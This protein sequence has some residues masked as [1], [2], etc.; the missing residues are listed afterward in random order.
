VAT[1]A[2]DIAT[3]GWELVARGDLRPARAARTGVIAACMVV[4]PAVHA[5]EP[6]PLARVEALGFDTATVGRVTAHFAPGDRQRATHLA[7]PAEG[8]AAFFEREIGLPFR[9]RLSVLSPEHWFSDWADRLESRSPAAHVRVPPLEPAE[10]NDNRSLA[11]T[12]VD[13]VLELRLETRLAAWR[14]DAEVDT[15]ATVLAFAEEGGPATIPGPFVRVPQGT[16]VRVNIRHAV[17]EPLRIGTPPPLQR[18]ALVPPAPDTPLIVHGLRAGT[19]ADDTLHVAPGTA[20]EV[21]FRADAPG[22]YLYW[23]ALSE[24]PFDARTGRDTQL[25]GAI[26]VDPAGVPADPDERVFVITV[27]D[28]WAD[29]AGPPPYEDIFEMAINGLSWP[30]TER[31]RYAVGDTVRWR[32]VNASF[33]RHPMHLHGFHFRTLAKGDG[34]TDTIYAPD[35]APLAVTE[36][37]EAGSTFRME[38]VPTRGGHWLFHCHFLGH[39]A[40]WPERDEAARAHDLHDVERHPLDGMAGLVIGITV[41][42]PTPAAADPEPQ[43]RLR[44][45]AQERRAPGS[46]AVIRGFVLQEGD[47]PPPDSVVVPGPPLLLTRDR[48]TAITVVNRLREPTTIHWHGMELES[49]YDGV[50]GWSRTGSRIAPLIAPGDSFV[51]SMTPPRTGTFIYHTH[52]DETD[53]LATGMYGAMLVLEPGEGFDPTRDHLF[54]IGE[55]VDGGERTLA[56]NGR[57]EPPPVTLTAGAAHRIRIININPDLTTDVAL[58]RGSSAL[59]WVSLAQD[60]AD[61]PPALRIESPARI[62]TGTGETYDFVWTPSEPGDAELLVHFPF[63]TDPGEL[64]LRQPLRVR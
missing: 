4:A 20:R 54:V 3:T 40:P 15:A 16:E 19:V 30:H 32:W 22:T 49:V 36:F 58:V 51:V 35:R 28:I 45:L 7:V 46:D 63:A 61:L 56:I 60:G 44:L 47:E 18:D 34:V 42:E 24:T 55:A 64:L 33:T 1:A 39:V 12:L 11:G 14:P 9:S 8:A 21:R 25:A 48:T 62:R 2:R 52:M 38:W 37:M 5:Q 6:S 17:T 53:Q 13:G 10:P 26:V 57:R 41:D 29:S 50:A 59:S 23:G 31:L 43:Q 27:I